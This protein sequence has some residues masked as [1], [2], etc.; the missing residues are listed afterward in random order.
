MAEKQNEVAVAAQTEIRCPKCG[1]FL[2]QRVLVEGRAI[3][4]F[5]CH[6][7]G[8]RLLATISSDSVTVGQV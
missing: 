7:C 2:C 5:A 8:S 1:R 4:K 3:L 6:S